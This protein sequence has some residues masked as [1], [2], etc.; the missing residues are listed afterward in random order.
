MMGRRGRL[1]LS[2]ICFSV[3]VFAQDSWQAHWHFTLGG[4]YNQSLY[5]CGSTRAKAAMNSSFSSRDAY[6]LQA[7]VARDVKFLF[8]DPNQ[9]LRIGA[10]CA[11]KRQDAYFYYEERLD[12]L[13]PT[14]TE[15]KVS[16]L[17]LNF[18]P[19][20][21]FGD[22]VRFLFYVG[23]NVEYVVGN[24][25]YT[26][27]LVEGESVASEKLRSD[28]VAGFS[29]GG[30]LGIGVEVPLSRSLC[31]C[32]Q[33]SYTSGYTS[34]EGILKSLYEFYNCFDINILASLIYTIPTH[35]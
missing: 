9:V 6:C 3:S 5:Y 26:T 31:F 22:N 21:V 1:L 27:R 15:Q 12:T 14:G 11:F 34:K 4:G 7:G 20:W 23:P 28:E 17:H 35:R 30:T 16:V 8:Q 19:Q 29:F 32:F 10:Q 25:S 13:I 18:F 2:L 24:R 33:N